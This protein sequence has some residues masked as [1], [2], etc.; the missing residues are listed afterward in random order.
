[1]RSALRVIAVALMVLV[2]GWTTGWA[3]MA[4]PTGDHAVQT[5][6]ASD[7]LDRLPEGKSDTV[8]VIAVGTLPQPTISIPV[9]IRNNTDATVYELELKAEIWDTEG[10]LVGV[11]SEAYG[12]YPI[13][14]NPGD[15]ALTAIQPDLDKLPA[16]V[17]FTFTLTYEA[18]PK[19]DFINDV[20][21]GEVTQSENRL[22]G[23]VA[24]PHDFP[25]EDFWLF[26]TCI[27]AEGVPFNFEI[28]GPDEAV[29]A[30]ESTSFQ[31][32]IRG[33]PC[34]TYLLTGYAHRVE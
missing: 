20:E 3:Q 18:E 22:L 7:S 17:E 34:D 29:G 14:L 10:K 33:A 21:F 26:A 1:M 11:E 9:L 4:T 12:I 2:P 23:E 5:T 28:G 31:I 32:D 30:D 15:I 27:D 6:V 19:Y 13:G 25:I 24:N 16:E 8:S